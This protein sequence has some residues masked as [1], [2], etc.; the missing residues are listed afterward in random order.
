MGDNI[1]SNEFYTEASFTQSLC[2][3][4]RYAL[5]ELLLAVFC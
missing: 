5:L 2:D 1:L 4:D 3:F